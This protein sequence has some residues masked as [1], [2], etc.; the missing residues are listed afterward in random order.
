MT[1]VVLGAGAIGSLYAAKLAAAHDVTVL[2]RPAHADAINRD[3]LRLVGCETSTHRL[4]AVASAADLPDADLFLLTTKVN[5]NEAMAAALAPRLRGSPVVL[6]VQ[7]GLGG[8]QIVRTVLGTRAA[9]LRAVTQFGAIFQRPGVVDYKVRGY[10]LIERG[11]R[12]EGVASL[13]TEA[14]LD[15]RVSDRIEDDVWRKL[16]FNC[17]INPITAVIGGHVGDIADPR[18]DPLKRLVIA[19]CLAVAHAS[20]IGL[21]FDVMTALTDIFGSSRN[22]ASM[23][24]DLMRGKPTEIDFMNGAIVD[25]GRQLGINCPVNAALVTLVKELERTAAT[26]RGG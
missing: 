5:D 11:A 22:I 15:G 17:V 16:I 23:R 9:V 20:G 12:S 8:E 2:A 3:G 19:E 25:R 26:E 18:L 4:V 1:I 14:G 24:Q 7:N 10:T 13:L 6:C 21:D